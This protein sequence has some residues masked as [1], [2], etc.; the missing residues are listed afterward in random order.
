MGMC[1]IYFCCNFEFCLRIF[2]YELVFFL[3]FGVVNYFYCILIVV[4]WVGVIV[5]LKLIIVGNNI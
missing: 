5:D 4:F 3:Y 2:L 1:E